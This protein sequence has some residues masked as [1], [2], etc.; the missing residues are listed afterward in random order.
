[1][2]VEKVAAVVRRARWFVLAVLVVAVLVASPSV[3]DA[4]APTGC[5]GGWQEQ[6]YDAIN[7]SFMAVAMLW[8]GL[9][10]VL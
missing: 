1:M 2:S 7:G 6:E 10:L 4:Q 5:W 8:I 9:W 3:A